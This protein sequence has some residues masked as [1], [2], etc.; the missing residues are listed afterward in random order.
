MTLYF[1]RKVRDI[2]HGRTRQHNHRHGEQYLFA[3]WYKWQP[4]TTNNGVQ[5]ING[6]RVPGP[7]GIRTVQS[8]GEGQDGNSAHVVDDG[9]LGAPRGGPGQVNNVAA[10]RKGAKVSAWT[11]LTQ[12]PGAVFGVCTKVAQLDGLAVGRNGGNGA[13][14][15]PTDASMNMFSKAVGT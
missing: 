5:V 13:L 6:I 11:R 10:G 3:L 8:H 2:L 14:P 15:R 1:E 9:E 12:A 7:Q 4:V